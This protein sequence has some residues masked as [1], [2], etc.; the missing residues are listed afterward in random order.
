MRSDLLFIA[1]AGRP[2]HDERA[3]KTAYGWWASIQV[4]LIALTPVP[5]LLPQ[6]DGAMLIAPIASGDRNATIRWAIGAGAKPLAPG[7]YAGS[8]VV[9]G[10]FGALLAPGLLHGALILNARFAGCG[11][12]DPRTTK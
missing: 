3:T 1:A 2:S 9:Q 10:S 12:P 11:T 7:P 8:Y 4:A 5:A 6:A